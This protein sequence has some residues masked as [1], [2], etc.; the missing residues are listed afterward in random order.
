MSES[1]PK[2]KTATSIFFQKPTFILALV[3]V[4]STII[5]VIS[6]SRANNQNKTAT[7]NTLSSSSSSSSAASSNFSSSNST[8]SSI[9][10]IQTAS[11]SSI[12]V[13]SAAPKPEANL[14]TYTNPFLP[15]LKIVYDKSWNFSTTTSKS[16]YPELVNRKI[17]LTKGGST[18]SF[19]TGP[20]VPTGCEG[21][22]EQMYNN[23]SNTKLV[24]GVYKNIYR[25]L[26]P[27][28][29]ADPRKAGINYISFG[30]NKD[31]AFCNISDTTE[32][33]ISINDVPVYKQ[34]MNYFGSSVLYVV[35]IGGFGLRADDPL[36][37][38]MEQ[39]ISQS[40]FW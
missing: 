4:L 30:K 2:Q 16:I 3:L 21:N 23:I 19:S 15:K 24:N 6:F 38:E 17:T 1:D 37:D 20:L 32:S 22:P 27:P 33:T 28:N 25:L 9:S 8:Q 29:P 31:S 39:I 10:S 7:Q 12:I 40:T 34:G 5:G 35:G 36:I 14:A 18:L 13:S 26:N 11:S